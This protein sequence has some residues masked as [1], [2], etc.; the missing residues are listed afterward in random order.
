MSR[1]PEA[2]RRAVRQSRPDSQRWLTVMVVLSHRTF[3]WS[4]SRRRILWILGSVAGIWAF[5]MVGSGYGLWSFRKVMSF[6][7]LQQETMEQQAQLKAS[8]EQAQ[9]ME[10]SLTALRDQQ[11]E[12]LRLLDPRAPAPALPQ[13]P[14]QASAPS[15]EMKARLSQ[16]RDHLQRNESQVEAIRSRMAPILQA[17]STTPSIPPTVGYL[18]SGFGVRVSPFANVQEKDDGLLSFHS[19][20]DISNQSGTPIQAT[21]EGEVV[22]AGWMDRYGQAVLVRHAE[23]LETLYAHME[24]VDVKMGQRVSRGDILG[25]MGATGRVTGVHLHYEVRRGG[26]AVDPSPYLKLQRQWLSGLGRTS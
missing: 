26:R 16:L 12:L 1:K 9:R 3:R 2:P 14:G 19:G 25:G 23:G 8:L 5:G 10:A 21:A 6:S 22:Q 24:R 18:S 17:W 4:V 7:Q 20:L 15:P 13:P 11:A